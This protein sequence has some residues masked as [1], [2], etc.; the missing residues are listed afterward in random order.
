M[1]QKL[2]S[3][4]ANELSIKPAQVAATVQLLDEGSTVPFI[5][6]YRK[7][8]TGT[9]D[10]VAITSIRDRI[11]Q[12]RELEKRREAILKSLEDREL[13]T[14][15]LED[16]I[17][18]AETMARL[19]DIY[20]PFRPKRRT[21]ATVAREKGL[22]P[23]A[24]AIYE[25][26]GVDPLKAAEEL[27]KELPDDVEDDKKVADAEEAL[28]GARDIIAEW[29]NEDVKAREKMR[30][31]FFKD[32]MII[33]SRFSE[34]D[35]DAEKY[36]D[37]FDYSEAV[38]TA[39]SHR[40]HAIFR[41]EREIHLSVKISPGEEKAT[42]LLEKLFLKSNSADGDQVKE[43]IADS[44]KRLLAPSME[45]EVRLELRLRAD[46]DAIR[47]FADNLRELLMASPFGEK[48]VLAIDPGF[49][50]GCK[51]AALDAQGSLLA[52]DTL[53]LTSGDAKA[54]QAKKQATN[55]IEKHQPRAIA[56]GNGTASRETEAF[57]KELV[58]EKKIP[59]VLVNESGAS[60][61]SASPVARK[62]FPDL[63]VSI[64]GAISIGRRLKD[65]LAELVKID[66]KSIGVGQYQHDVDQNKLKQSLD[67]VVVSC[68]NKVGVDLNTSSA[69]LLQYV[70]GVGPTLGEN[71]V[72]Y[73][74]KNGSFKSRS[75]L[76]NVTR[77]GPKAF[78]QAAGFI[79]IR[80]GQNP[81]DASAVH[82]ERYALV[83]KMAKDAGTDVQT[84]M[85]DEEK[86]KSIKLDTYVSD[87]VGLPTLQDIMAELAKPGRDPRESFVPFSFAEG[88]ETMDDLKKGMKLPG[89]VTNVTDFGAFVDVGVHQDGLVHKSKMPIRRNVA[90][91]DYVK[92]GQT[93]EVTV[94]DV[95][96]QRKRISLSML[97]DQKPRSQR[98]TGK[99]SQ[100]QSKRPN[101][102][103]KSSGGQ[104]P[105]QQEKSSG[106]S[107]NPFADLMK[108]TKK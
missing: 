74:S 49:R 44:Y 80:G 78:E 37:Y 61:Y 56:I 23:L 50:T 35:K 88:V 4:V 58:K 104:K 105:R 38:K 33:S 103:P 30:D 101:R 15:E 36:R 81:L 52:H 17:K 71:I 68:V 99:T 98:K 46:E 3:A 22:E 83:E 11:E 5:A 62:E 73:R 86:R 54:E 82:P 59:V 42:A 107:H 8:K 108:K 47:V 12:L 16:D 1:S 89:I 21:R 72:K 60:V 64:R 76:L 69:Q 18:A 79:R 100:K 32:G 14:V 90:P 20:L 25:Q 48:P 77:F 67:D 39:A 34:E 27:L 102:K 57:F 85:T 29:I 10:E 87:D 24:T 26:T 95:D 66:A 31:L 94:L 70:S 92:V 91:A 6:R 53:Y 63:D 75:E 41:G 84:L 97:K 40:I 13:L 43:A 55:L 106:F 2:F 28:A 65:P 96:Q 9:L 7:E 19:E 93:I 45:N 51:A